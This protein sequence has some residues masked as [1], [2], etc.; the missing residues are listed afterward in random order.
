MHALQ[1]LVGPEWISFHLGR[2]ANSTEHEDGVE[3]RFD[4]GDDVRVHPVTDHSRVL[5]VSPD[6][7]HRRAEHHRVRLTDDVGLF[8]GG[9]GDECG[10]GAGGGEWSIGA[11]A[12]RIRIRDN[13][14]RARPDQADGFGDGVEGVVASLADDDIVGGTLRHDEAGFV[15][16]GRDTRLADDEGGPPGHLGCEKVSGGEGGCPEKLFGYIETG[17]PEPR[18]QIAGR[19]DRVVGEHE[20]R[21]SAIAPLLQQGGSPRECVIFVDEH[22]VHVGEPAFDIVARRHAAIVPSAHTGQRAYRPGRIPTRAHTDQG[23]APVI[24]GIRAR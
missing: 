2:V 7:V 5:G 20:E 10:D 13:E 18:T 21:I 8:A 1:H 11:R 12:G 23:T 17:R 22:P 15:Q 19:E 3:T 4:S 6:L 24:A 9:F 14:S 16:C